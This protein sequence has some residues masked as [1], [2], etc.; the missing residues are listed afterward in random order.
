VQSVF[1]ETEIDRAAYC[2]GLALLNIPVGLP[3]RVK[4]GRP[5]GAVRGVADSQNFRR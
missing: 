3:S 5:P 2:E 1:A 4:G